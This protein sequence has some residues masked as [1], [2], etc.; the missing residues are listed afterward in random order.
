MPV[1]WGTPCSKGQSP[2]GH[3]SGTVSGRGGWE[4]W[5]ESGTAAANS[6]IGTLKMLKMYDTE[7]RLMPVS[8]AKLPPS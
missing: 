8:F 7:I 4:I 2:F 3:T 1:V 5:G 6:P